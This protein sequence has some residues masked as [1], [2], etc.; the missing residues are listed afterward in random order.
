MKILEAFAFGLIAKGICDDYDKVIKD[1]IAIKE[2]VQ[3]D[4]V[5]IDRLSKC[6]DE[7]IEKMIAAQTILK[8]I[9]NQKGTI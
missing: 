4:K 8:N 9:Y 2:P 3:Y 7:V 6:M 5:S 1:L